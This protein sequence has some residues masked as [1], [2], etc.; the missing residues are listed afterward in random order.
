MDSGQK[1][2][3]CG[4]MVSQ[5]SRKQN[6]KK[7]GVNNLPYAT[8]RSHRMETVS[9][10]LGALDKTNVRSFVVLWEPKPKYCGF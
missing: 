6:F 2:E 8:E 1:Q 10:Q 9:E 5:A 4:A 3:N 7:Q